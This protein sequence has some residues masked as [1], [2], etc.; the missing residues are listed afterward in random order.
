DDLSRRLERIEPAASATVESPP[1]P[2]S[3]STGPFNFDFDRDAAAAGPSPEDVGTEPGVDWRL[4]GSTTPLP[5]P[6]RF[7]VGDYDDE[8]GAYVLVR[9]RDTQRLPFELRFDL[10]TQ[11]RYTNFARQT[12]TWTNAIGDRLPV[13]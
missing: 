4:E 10:V 8:F 11:M 1:P 12:E 13:R 9:S 3:D 7:L 2:P 6:S 5:E